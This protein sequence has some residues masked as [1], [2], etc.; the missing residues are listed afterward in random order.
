ME[1][2]LNLY[3]LL[4]AQEGSPYHMGLLG[5]YLR[6]E[7]RDAVNLNAAAEWSKAALKEGHPFGCII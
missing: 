4:K 3:Q 2:R 7:K 5:I 6:S 1:P